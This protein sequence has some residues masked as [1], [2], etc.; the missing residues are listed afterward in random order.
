MMIRN[1]SLEYKD[2]LKD[3]DILIFILYF[4]RL[5]L[6]CLWLGLILWHLRSMVGVFLEK[7]RVLVEL[8]EEVDKGRDMMKTEWPGRLCYPSRVTAAVCTVFDLNRAATDFDLALRPG[9]MG[10]HQGLSLGAPCQ[11]RFSTS[12]ASLTGDGD[13]VTSNPRQNG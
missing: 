9:R 12:N 5:S 1:M 4:C 2:M 7:S 10:D 6:G 8:Q 11:G 13:I 3:V